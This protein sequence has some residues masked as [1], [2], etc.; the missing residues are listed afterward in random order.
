MRA[1]TEIK[2]LIVD[3]GTKND[4]VRAILLNGSRA[5]PNARHDKFQ[6]FDIVFLVRQIKS[7]TDDHLWTDIF[8]KKLI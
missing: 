1:E 3:F 2:N 7:F 6:D 8:G 4:R 5:N